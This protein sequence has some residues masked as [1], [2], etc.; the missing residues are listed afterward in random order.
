[1]DVLK[2]RKL[3]RCLA[4][5]RKVLRD[6]H[7]K[8]LL[9]LAYESIN[10]SV[11]NK[12]FPQNYLEKM[13]YRRDVKSYMN[14]LS[15]KDMR[16]LQ[17]AVR[18]PQFS[19]S[20][21][22]KVLFHNHFR[23]SGIELPGFLGFNIGERFFTPDG[24]QVISNPSYFDFFMK[25]LLRRSKTSSVFA[26]PVNGMQG[27]DCFRFDSLSRPDG[28]YEKIRNSYY[29]FEQTIV[30]HPAISAIYP[31]S[32]NT[33]RIVTCVYQ[34]GRADLV[35]AI[36]RFGTSRSRTDNLHGG[37]LFVAVDMNTGML[38]SK[39]RKLFGCGGQECFNHPDTGVKFGGIKVPHFQS[40]LQVTRSAVAYFPYPLV[41]WDIAITKEGPVLIE[42]NQNS[43]FDGSEIAEGGFRVNRAFSSFLEESLRG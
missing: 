27:K 16:R 41:G 25:D 17:C 33:L 31:H 43:T 19:S 18:R 38:D 7:R 40:A 23:G 24:D 1:M 5:G 12:E 30:Q 2:F 22:N 15:R 29:L 11:R 32:I 26:K 36:M 37:G 14:F 21:N 4:T 42:G 28:A 10:Y 34:D 9:R 35:S 3:R 39:A 13:M 6:E 8:S 20:F